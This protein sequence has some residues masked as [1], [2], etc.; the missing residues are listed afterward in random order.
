MGTVEGFWNLFFVRPGWK[1]HCVPNVKHE[2]NCGRWMDDAGVIARSLLEAL[3]GLHQEVS[4]FASCRPF[5][6]R[7]ATGPRG[8]SNWEWKAG[9]KVVTATLV[10]PT[11]RHFHRPNLTCAP[12][13]PPPHGW[14]TPVPLVKGPSANDGPDPF[15]A[16]SRERVALDCGGGGQA[17]LGI[18]RSDCLVSQRDGDAT[19]T[20]QWSPLKYVRKRL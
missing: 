1:S 5:P 4:I 19:S 18:S 11:E 17:A 6:W 13:A 14:L 8:S 15:F 12:L 2:T 20:W 9:A 3:G 7:A 10:L 16:Q